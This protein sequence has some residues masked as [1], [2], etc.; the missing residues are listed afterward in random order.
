MAKPK[1]TKQFYLDK[2]KTVYMLAQVVPD[3]LSPG[4]QGTKLERF[5]CS[6]E[7]VDKGLG[8]VE[9]DGGADDFNEVMGHK[10]TYEEL[11][12]VLKENF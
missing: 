2:T 1:V 7:R 10:V 11:P 8:W 3:I 4:G 5:V 9:W 12:D 6:K